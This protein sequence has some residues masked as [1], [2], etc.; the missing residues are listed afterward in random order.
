MKLT[1]ID[2]ELIHDEIDEIGNLKLSICLFNDSYDV[3]VDWHDDNGFM[4][5]KLN[6]SIDLVVDS[7][8]ESN[9]VWSS[10]EDQVSFSEKD[11]RIVDQLKKQL[12]EGLDKLN[13]I[14]YVPEYEG[15]ENSD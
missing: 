8:I 9:E 4:E 10:T 2:V 1:E 7:V 5:L 14:K 15:E 11:K 3:P 13:K 12:Q 6:F